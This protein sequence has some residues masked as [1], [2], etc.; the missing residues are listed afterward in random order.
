MICLLLALEMTVKGEYHLHATYSVENGFLFVLI[1]PKKEWSSS[2]RMSQFLAD[3]LKSLRKRNLE[4]NHRLNT[5]DFLFLFVFL[6]FIPR[7]SEITVVGENSKWAL[8][9]CQTLC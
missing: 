3:R 6:F 9:G 7:Y 4:K 5:E 2:L 8:S 1:C